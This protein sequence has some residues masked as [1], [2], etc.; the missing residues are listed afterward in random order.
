MNQDL[1]SIEAEV[2]K[3]L[4]EQLAPFEEYGE[5]PRSLIEK[6]QALLMKNDISILESKVYEDDFAEYHYKNLISYLNESPIYAEYRRLQKEDAL[7]SVE[8]SKSKILQASFDSQQIVL[9][10]TAISIADIVNT[11]CSTLNI[12]KNEQII[13]EF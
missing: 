11:A 2:I 13:K 3:I 4:Q 10:D 1:K 5:D 12:K 8:M 9:K 6:Y 7:S